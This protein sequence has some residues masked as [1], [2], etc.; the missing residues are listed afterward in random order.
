MAAEQ[1]DDS[2]AQG[3]LRNQTMAVTAVR[4]PR[5]RK[6][7]PLV[8]EFKR[9]VAL[10]IATVDLSP[11]EVG[12]FLATVFMD[13]PAG[14]RLLRQ[15]KLGES[16]SKEL[17]FGI[18]WSPSEFAAE[19]AKARHPFQQQ[20]PLPDVLLRVIFDLVTRGPEFVSRSRIARLAYWTKVAKELDTQE[21]D[22]RKSLQPEVRDV[23]RGKRLLLFKRMLEESGY[24]V[25]NYLPMLLRVS[26]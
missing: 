15:T 6:F 9:V 25:R 24:I 16:G 21:L 10:T 14:S 20:A 5:G 1:F 13:V 19:A 17:V 8:S 2:W 7:P 11:I 12:K 23:L 4:Q 18:P 22:F 26:R 3:M